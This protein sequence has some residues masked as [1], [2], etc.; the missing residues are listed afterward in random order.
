MDESAI[1]L[2]N[3]QAGAEEKTEVPFADEQKQKG[4]TETGKK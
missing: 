4:K 1:S 2:E 3:Y